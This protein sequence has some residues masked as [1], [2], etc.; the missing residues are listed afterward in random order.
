MATTGNRLRI[1]SVQYVI[2]SVFLRFSYIGI[3]YFFRSFSSLEKAILH[4]ILAVASLLLAWFALQTFRRSSPSG[5]ALGC[6]YLVLLVINAIGAL[7]AFFF[8]LVH[9]FNAATSS[10]E[11]SGTL[12]LL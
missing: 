11:G 12:W 9:L 1:S 2:G 7:G 10:T 4:V 3:A 5:S 8:A 6:T